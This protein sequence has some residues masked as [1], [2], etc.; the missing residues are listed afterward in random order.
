MFMN[1]ISLAFNSVSTVEDA[2]QMI[3]N[4]DQLAKRQAI[5]DFVQTK[6]AERVFNMFLQ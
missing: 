5:K 3:D 2:V 6:A 4:F 1:I